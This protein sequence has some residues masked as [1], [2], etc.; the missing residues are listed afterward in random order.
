[1]EISS[2]EAGISTIDE[3]RNALIDFKQSGKF[4]IAYSDVYMQPAYYLASVADSL[5]LNPE[6]YLEFRGVKGQ[7]VFIKGLLSKLEIEAQL[8]RHG[9]YKSAGEALYLDKMSNENREQ[10][11][12][13]I[14]AIW[15]HI[16]KGISET[17][18]IPVDE[19]NA[20]ADS[21]RLRNAQDALNNKFVDGTVYYDEI[22]SLMRK[23][24]DIGEKDKLNFVTLAKY[25]K[26][27]DKKDSKKIPSEKIAIVYAQGDI[28]DGEGDKDQVGGTAFAK[29]IREAR[30]NEKVKAVVLR[31]NSPGGSALAS[32]IILRE[33]LLTKKIKP[34]IVSMGDVA[35]S[36][37]YYISCAADTIFARPTTITGSIGVFGVIPNAQGFFNNKLGITFDG[38]ETN[39]YSDFMS[40]VRPLDQFERNVI[41]QEIERIYETFI[42]H[43]AKGRNKTRDEVDSVGQG[44]VW[45]G[46]DAKQIGLIDSYGGLADA[47]DFAAKKAGIADYRLLEL[48]KKKD[49]FKQIIEEITGESE[50]VYLQEKFGEFYPYLKQIEKMKNY[51]GIQARLPVE[52][53]IQ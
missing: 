37:G 14:G 4:I 15:N 33:V 11:T 39:T 24:I 8:I 51:S 7:L 35:A 40:T 27:P 28:V 10:Y 32:E 34:V 30:E 20:I 12:A 53:S 42:A 13:F 19:L 46:T 38:V 36:G 41:F 2:V 16:L 31:V 29:A 48:P 52:I 18:K 22:L 43:V 23:K 45:S 6:G 1:M 44:R 50:A 25:S 17:R 47:I 49:P 9:K 3:I 26:A 21:L 5:F